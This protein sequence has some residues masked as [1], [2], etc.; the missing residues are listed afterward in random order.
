MP[1][2]ILV[3]GSGFAGMW[4]ALAAARQLDLAGGNASDIEI[5]LVAPEPVLTIRPRL[6]EA[7]AASMGV[8]LLDLFAA[9]GIRYI[10]GK[11]ESISTAT[12]EVMIVD[13]SAASSTLSYDRLVLASGSQLFVPDVPGLREHAFSIDQLADA[14][15]LE[16]H[17][18]R[19]ATL[20][21]SQARNTF[22][23]AGG[24]F[25]GI[26]LAA[27]L[28]ARMRTILGQDATVLLIEKEAA[29]GPDLGAGPRPVIEQ[30]LAELGVECR[31]NTSVAKVER[32]ALTTSNGERIETLTTVWT[33]GLRA[34]PLT[35][36]VPG[37]RDRLGRL[38]TDTDLRVSGVQNVFATGDTAYAATDDAG[39]HALMS[40]QHA[41]NLGK[42]AGHNAAA[43]LLGL[44]TQPYRQPRYV[45][46]LDL[47]PWGAVLTEG[48]DR[49][50]R[51]QGADAKNLKRH[52][53]GTLIYPPPADRVEALAAADPA[54]G[55]R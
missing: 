52:I 36:H 19:L 5:A 24:G 12:S 41:M 38:H 29:I 1:Q 46:C 44:P 49:Q 6:Y 3:I 26:E 43:D 22:V 51:M 50:V 37:E 2:R 31:L 10:R 35:Q 21:N 20:P 39:N 47:G 45:T 15:K 40:C 7:D 16:A 17:C 27:E 18:H 42:S 33:A 32:D 14:A 25:T 9:T 34:S 13:G 54:G 23:V 55:N 30:A 11:V 53:N 8:S 48:W 28:P 4:S